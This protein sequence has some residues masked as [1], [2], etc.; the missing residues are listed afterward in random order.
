MSAAGLRLQSAASDST[1]S[2][3]LQTAVISGDVAGL[4]TAKGSV[5]H[6][7][8]EIP[9][10]PVDGS[11]IERA[12][13]SANDQQGALAM[14]EFAPIGLSPADATVSPVR[15]TPF[16]LVPPVSATDATRPTGPLT[17][18]IR[19]SLTAESVVPTEQSHPELGASDFFVDSDRPVVAF[20]AVATEGA[21]AH[22]LS[23]NGSSRSAHD[24]IR[25]VAEPAKDGIDSLAADH[26]AVDPPIGRTSHDSKRSESPGRSS[27]AE[28]VF[29]EIASHVDL[30]RRDGKIDFRMRLDPPG[31]GTVQV[32]L[33][34][35]DDSISARLI[36]SDPAA[37]DAIESQLHNLRESLAELGVSLDYFGAAGDD[38]RSGGAWQWQRPAPP[39]T[40]FASNEPRTAKHPQKNSARRS[41]GVID[42]VG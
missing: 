24:R 5:L 19:D 16:P 25:S 6:R 1:N 21:A 23:G 17:K 31:M 42:V 22:D 30:S 35:S 32:H 8:A 39:S 41:S 29:G 28:Q 38:G 12:M 18:E 14:D 4:G 33:T 34:A 20:V 9:S 2:E 3:S 40:V 10:T 15:A 27:I 11:E 7:V 13:R 26:P 37:H 36:V